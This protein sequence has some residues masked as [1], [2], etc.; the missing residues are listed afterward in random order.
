MD[1]NILFLPVAVVYVG[2]KYYLYNQIFAVWVIEILPL[3]S[4]TNI[5]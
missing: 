2:K 1:Q 4:M 5:M 3:L